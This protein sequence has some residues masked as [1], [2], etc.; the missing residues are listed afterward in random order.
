M[1]KPKYHTLFLRLLYLCAIFLSYSNSAFNQQVTDINVRA[2]YTYQ[3][4]LNITW[5]NETKLDTFRIFLI[6]DNSELEKSIYDIFLQGRVKGKPVSVIKSPE[7]NFSLGFIPNIVYVDNL[8][9]A[10][11]QKANDRIGRD[12]I[13]LVTEESSSDQPVMINLF[14]Q[15][16][17]RTK[18]TFELNKPRIEGRGLKI[19][20]QLLI[21]GAKRVEVAELYEQQEEQLKGERERAEL[22]KTEIAA[23][24]ELI[25]SQNKQIKEQVEE[26]SEK[27]ILLFQKQKQLDVLSAQLDTVRVEVVTQQNQLETNFKLIE[28]QRFEFVRQRDQLS[29][30]ENKI[31]ER[32]KILE[33]QQSEI[34]AQQERI[35]QQQQILSEQEI[36][37]VDQKRWLLLSA[38]S[39]VLVLVVMMLMVRGYLIKRKANRILEEKNAAIEYQNQQIEQQKGEI[40]A[41]A[42]ELEIQNINLEA[43]VEK[44][45]REFKLAKERAEES[46]RLKTA[47]LA[48]MSHEIRTPLNAIIGFSELIYTQKRE[49]YTDDELAYLK[50]I[51]SSSYDL[52][53]LINDIIDIAK[54]E[55]G[56]LNLEFSNSDI[57]NEMKLLHSTYSK[58]LSSKPDKQEIDFSLNIHNSPENLWVKTD[59]YR[60]KQVI[61]NLL[62][63]AIKFTEK[64]QVEFGFSVNQNQIEFFVT[65]TGIGIPLEY[66]KSLFQRF[67]KIEHNDDKLYPGT[68][69]G[70]VIS[71]N[72]VELMGGRIWFQSKLNE[73][74]KFFFTIPLS[75]INKKVESK[76]IFDFNSNSLTT[77]DGRIVLICEDDP[78]SRDLLCRYLEVFKIKSISTCNGEEALEQFKQNP[79]IDL[80]LLDIQLPGMNGFE[81]L[82]AIRK[83]NQKSVPVVAQTAFAMANDEK[84]I[85]ESGFDDYLSKPFLLHDLSTILD[86]FFSPSI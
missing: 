59:A 26:L 86:R 28:M 63:N 84:K 18:M 7:A 32:N 75:T 78:H 85:K 50:V 48:N 61:K 38:T 72:L 79:N 74:T 70:L 33:N 30:Q 83:T 55:S 11:T 57:V 67:V 65:D 56:Q 20:P 40:E 8:K 82:N 35:S 41:Q 68:G 66:Q 12:P 5:P 3:F 52:L 42:N 27:Q 53:R 69:L 16:N 21:R 14:Y 13:L 62:D 23:Q 39:V 24:R 17:D 31:D 10:Y 64:G 58:I 73:G 15:D 22:L 44:R 36:Q 46:D 9:K 81:I 60:L 45:T 2:A 29:F 77:Y 47:F 51:I 4:A 34:H 71:K 76:P 54:I 43:I 6:S 1:T 37:L 49:A 19:S 80:V 25:S